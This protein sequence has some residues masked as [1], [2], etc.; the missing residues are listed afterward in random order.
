MN[1]ISHRITHV[2]LAAVA[3]F[4]FACPSASVADDQDWQ[5]RSGAAGVVMATRF[6]TVGEVDDYVFPNSSAFHVSWDTLN[7]VSGNGSLRMDILKT[8]QAGSGAWVRHLSDAAEEFG[9]GKTFYVQFRQF[10]PGYYATHPFA[11]NASGQY[12]G[13]WKQAI[14]SNM[15]GSNQI[16]EV[17]M[18][19]TSHRGFVQGYNR[20]SNGSYLGFEDY[21]PTP[22]SGS[23]YVFQN[24]VDRGFGTATFLDA[25]R[26][27]GGLYSYATT[28]GSP[29]PETGAF[30]FYPDEWLTFMIKIS[31]GT[32]GGGA[33]VR[34]SNVMIW[35]ARA[36]DTSYTLLIDKMTNLGRASDDA[37]NPF[38]FDAVWLLPY[39]TKRLPDPSRAD[40]YTLYDELIVSKQFIAPPNADPSAPGAAIPQRITDLVVQ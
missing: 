5:A 19:N 16:F 32:F 21:L 28:A 29:D 2:A 20:N 33:D 30:L 4:S 6:D 14:F 23:D 39:N 7:K 8:D 27:L 34:D 37:G 35:A 12:A 15:R 17:V 24:K 22:C 13:G 3:A 11:G 26:T 36:A 18:Q 40:T 10:F 9:P 25:R 1:R 38:Y 31:P